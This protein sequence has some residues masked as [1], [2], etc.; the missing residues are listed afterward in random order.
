VNNTYVSTQNMVAQE[1]NKPISNRKAFVKKL[2]DPSYFGGKHGMP[3]GIMDLDNR[4][5]HRGVAAGELMLFIGPPGCGKS[6]ALMNCAAYQVMMGH[7]VLFYTLELSAD[8][9]EMRVNSCLSSIPINDMPMN[10]DAVDARLDILHGRRKFGELIVIDLPANSLKPSHVR[11]DIRRYR[12]LGYNLKSFIIDYQQLMKSDRA[13]ALS[14]RRIEYGDVCLEIR[15]IAKDEKIAGFS[16]VQGN[17]GA[18][19]KM[20]VDLD[21]VAEDYS[22]AFTADYVLGISQTKKE[23]DMSHSSGLGSGGQIRLFVGKN[24]NEKKGDSIQLWPDFTRMR[25]SMI[26]WSRMD[27]E[28]Y[29]LPLIA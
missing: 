16:A 28:I 9:N 11:R 7:D 14:D 27:H 24:R 10:G 20:D 23:K 8:I 4:L 19:N 1:D 22:A 6:P 29:G 15:S 25:F 18:L 3:T 26:D 2:N 12:D 13:M 21:S 17:R 5:L